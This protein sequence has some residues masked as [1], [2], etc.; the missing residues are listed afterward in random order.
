MN[1]PRNKNED[2]DLFLEL[3]NN[4]YKTA[5][6]KLNFNEEVSVRLVSD[7]DNSFNAL[8][9]TAADNPASKEIFLYFA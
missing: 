8:G 7:K 3:M 2:L 4:L 5:K 1:N 6:N 9:K